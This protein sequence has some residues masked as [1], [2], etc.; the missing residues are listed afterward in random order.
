MMD[1][2][3]MEQTLENL[4]G[5]NDWLSAGEAVRLDGIRFAKRRTDWRLGRWTAKLALA[6][7]LHL[8]SHPQCF[9]DIEIRPA[10]SGA[11]EVFVGNQAAA[12]TIS[13]SHR[14][15]VAACAVAFPT[16]DLGCDLE[17]IEPRSD[18]FIADYFAAEE[19]ALIERTPAADRPHLLALLWSA[20]ESTLKALRTGLRLDTRSV[21]VHPGRPPQRGDE[22]AHREDSSLIFPPADGLNSWQPLRV[23]YEGDQVFH[24]WWQNTGN[25][26]RTMVA[27]PAPAPPILLENP[28]H[29]TQSVS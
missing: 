18:A 25:L 27:S 3:W 23:A 14:D 5:E 29:S 22:D 8:P 15:G 1:V 21:T 20:K 12:V 4:P 11:P 24:G 6:H 13:L 28:D 9:T 17:I 7:Y 16:V 10:Q 19:Q 2:Y 26:L